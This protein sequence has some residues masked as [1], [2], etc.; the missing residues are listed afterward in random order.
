MSKFR[1]EVY[2][3]EALET[4]FKGLQRADKKSIMMSAFRKALKPTVDIMYANAPVGKTGN[5]Q[6]SIGMVAARDEVAMYA[7]A[8]IK[9]GFRGYHGHLVEEGTYQRFRKT[10]GGAPT[11]KMPYN[12]FIKRACDS[13]EKHAIDTVQD[14][15]YKAITRFI[16]RNK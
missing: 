4:T 7:G 8:R 5:L 1:M 6:K 12:G 2:G 16:R 10:K 3:L 9:G 13:T 14:E 11:G 15:W